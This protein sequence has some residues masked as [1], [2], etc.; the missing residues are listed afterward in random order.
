MLRV[1]FGKRTC[2]CRMRSST[3]SRIRYLQPNTRERDSEENEGGRDKASWRERE[4]GGGRVNERDRGK[5]G[6]VGG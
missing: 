2:I 1:D 3:E 5:R 4:G 6:V